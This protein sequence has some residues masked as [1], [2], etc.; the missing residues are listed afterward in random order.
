KKIRVGMP[1]GARAR[2]PLSES[3]HFLDKMIQC[4]L[5]RIREW[6][7]VN[8]QGDGNGS[9]S[10]TLPASSIGTFPDIEPH[11]DSFPRLYDT[12][13]TIHT[14]AVNDWETCLLLSGFQ[15]PFLPAVKVEHV[16][17]VKSDDPWAAI[18]AAKTREERK[19]LFAAM[20]KAQAEAKAAKAKI[21]AEE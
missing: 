4:V 1:I 14:T 20:Q 12:K 2:L 7:G 8:P 21:A 13:V 11:F 15:L 18:K 9:I 16:D 10:F 5:P 3:Y 17:L 19:A 6:E